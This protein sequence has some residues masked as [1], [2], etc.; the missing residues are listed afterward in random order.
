MRYFCGVDISKEWLDAFASSTGA[1]K[2]FSNTPDGVKALAAF[3]RAAGVELVVM[4]ASGGYEQLVFLTLWGLGQPCAITNARAVRDF[5]RKVEVYPERLQGSRRA[6]AMG[7]LEKTDKI[8]AEM[9]AKFGAAKPL[10]PTLPPSEDQQ[11]MA[12]LVARLRQ[13]TSDTTIQK[14]RLA[15]ARDAVMRDGLIE[16]I[17]LLKRQSKAIIASIAAMIETDPVWAALDRTFRSIKGVAD[18]TVALV[19]AELPEI[20]T[21]SNKAIGKLVGLAPLANDSGKRQGKRSIRGGRAGVRSVLY[22]VADIARKYDPSLAAFR[23]RLLASGKPKMVVRIAI[24]RK[25]LTRLNA[26]A[27]ETRA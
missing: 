6:K 8:D 4:E 15:S 18:K 27:R 26:K 2:R 14:Q 11:K 17:A 21:L 16:V 9:I 1:F 24:A 13:I 19:L 12:A 23:E 20:G 25:L 3:C 5:D 10:A 22:L 7:Q